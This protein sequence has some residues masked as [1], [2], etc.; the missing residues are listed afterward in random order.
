MKI[1]TCRD[2]WPT[3][4]GLQPTALAS[5][6]FEVP[7]H[8]SPLSTRKLL[9]CGIINSN[10]SE[11]KLSGHRQHHDR[12]ASMATCVLKTTSS[13]ECLGTK[14]RK[15][16]SQHGL[17]RVLEEC[18]TRVFWRSVLQ[19]C[20]MQMVCDFFWSR[21]SCML[22]TGLFQQHVLS[23]TYYLHLSCTV[24]DVDFWDATLSQLICSR[25]VMET[26][27]FH[28]QENTEAFLAQRKVRF[29]GMQRRCPAMCVCS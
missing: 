9:R 19:E 1:R 13:Q 2:L 14:P 26:F 27:R 10:E 3:Y 18:A 11:N 4:H 22:G 24:Y 6:C 16:V 12:H 28:F 29:E 20:P 7:W 15:S 17:I 8:S 25:F 21:V 23:F 5:A